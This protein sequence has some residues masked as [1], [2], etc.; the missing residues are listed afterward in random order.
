MIV[1]A[2]MLVC[3]RF[4]ELSHIGVGIHTAAPPTPQHNL[5]KL[6][7]V[8]GLVGELYRPNYEPVSLLISITFWFLNALGLEFL[9]RGILII[10]LLVV[11]LPADGLTLRQFL[12]LYGNLNEGIEVLE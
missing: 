1:K 3:C 8:V 7:R 2:E 12:R 11:E 10:L 4:S 6:L 5:L 9:I